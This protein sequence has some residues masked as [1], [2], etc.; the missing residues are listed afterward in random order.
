MT[1]ALA[2]TIV[3]VAAIM[4]QHGCILLTDIGKRFLMPDLGQH[5]LPK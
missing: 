2:D 4:L 1:L 5:P 3:A